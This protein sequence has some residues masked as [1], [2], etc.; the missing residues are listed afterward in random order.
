M[1]S[2]PGNKYSF[3]MS[4]LVLL[5]MKMSLITGFAEVPLFNFYQKNQTVADY[6]SCCSYL[7]TLLRCRVLLALKLAFIITN[8]YCQCLAL[9][10]FSSCFPQVISLD[11]QTHQNQTYMHAKAYYQASF[12][13]I[14]SPCTGDRLAGQGNLGPFYCLFYILLISVSFISQAYDTGTP[15]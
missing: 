9:C 13:L 3:D 12:I 11:K 8:T 6:F 2:H 4:R 1:E 15:F 5:R 14:Y 7:V 10:T